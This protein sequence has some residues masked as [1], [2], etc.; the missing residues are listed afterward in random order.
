M[1]SLTP[2]FERVA[3]SQGYI[4]EADSD[5]LEL[6]VAALYCSTFDG[7]Q[8]NDARCYLFT[9]KGKTI[10]NIPPTAQQGVYCY[11]KILYYSLSKHVKR[12][13]LQVRK[14]YNCLE[15]TRVALEPTLVMD[16]DDF[17]SSLKP[18]ALCIPKWRK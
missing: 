4:Y 10:D 6:F 16:E 11:S 18:H 9:S 8:V 14:W 15:A 13:V 3:T 2:V 7:T 17:F 5:L 12:S 1:P